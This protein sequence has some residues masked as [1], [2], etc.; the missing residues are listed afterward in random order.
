LTKI[1]LAGTDLLWGCGSAFSRTPGVA[2]F[3]AGAAAV[4]VAE[5]A[6]GAAADFFFA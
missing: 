2:G 1:M 4:A 5:L 6:A 3:A